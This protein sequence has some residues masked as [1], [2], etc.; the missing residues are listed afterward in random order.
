MECIETSKC[1]AGT[2]SLGKCYCGTLSTAACGAAPFDLTAAG[3]PNGAC[4]ALMQKGQPGV[5][6]N[7][8]MLG[9]LTNK[10]RPAGAAG[11]RLNCDKTDANC[12]PI[13]GGGLN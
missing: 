10:S 8:A 7:S 11:Q 6:T 3:A 5:A 9:A 1:L 4:A 12:A 2:G 13:C